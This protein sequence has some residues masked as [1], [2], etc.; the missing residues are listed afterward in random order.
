MAA[1]GIFG[2]SFDPIH[3]GHLITA[4]DVLIK[5]KLEKIILVPCYISPHKAALSYTSPEHRLNM[6]RL[7]VQDHPFFEVS[8]FEINKHDISYTYDTLVEFS[9]IYEEM[10][11]IIGFDNLLSFDLWKNPDGILEFAKLVVLKRHFEQKVKTH[12]KYFGKAVFV[13]SPTIEI[14]ASEI[15]E[16][17][18]NNLPIDFLVPEAVKNYI[19]E[20][21]LYRY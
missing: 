5:R 13:D 15:R 18:R 21:N 7:A 20:H 14:S 1:V 19:F 16:K 6:V 8:E 2:G 17:I 4:Q 12:N 10:E 3:H 9:K 11:L